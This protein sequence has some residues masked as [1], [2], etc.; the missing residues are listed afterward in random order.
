MTRLA[1]A[2]LP[3]RLQIAVLLVVTQLL[4]HFVTIGV[5]ELST[6]NLRS[7]QADYVSTMADPLITAL[8][9]VSPASEDEAAALLVDLAETDPRFTVLSAPKPGDLALSENFDPDLARVVAGRVPPAW[10]DRVTITSTGPSPWSWRRA[11]EAALAVLV[12]LP[13]GRA[14]R[15][16]SDPHFLGP[17]LPTVVIVPA[18]LLLALPLM[19]LSVWAGSALVAPITSLAR[20]AERF[21]SDIASPPITES[22]PEEV[23]RASRAFN[24]MRVRIRKLIDS[25]S[26]TL[27][28]IGHDMR[29]PLTRLRLRLEALDMGSTTSAAEEDIRSLERMIDDAL[30]FLQ[31]E[32]QPLVLGAI[33][34]AVLAQ[35]IVDDFADRGHRVRYEGPFHLPLVCDHDHIRRVLENLVGNATKYAEDT[36][37]RV[38]GEDDGSLTIHVADYGPG[39]APEHHEHVLEPFS[40]IETVRRGGESAGKSFGLGLAIA[41]DLVTRH[42]GFLKLGQN[43]PEGLLVTIRLPAPAGGPPHL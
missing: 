7:R 24:A 38:T 20:G 19:L 1:I 9:L 22:G 36:L 6:P 33:D 13:D 27:A 23:R 8:R 4:A 15:Y 37:V 21:S 5:L 28:A 26:Q 35:T 43:V 17:S 40:R 42:G 2:R 30:V 32:Q 3:I 31:S 10:R 11:E 14:V 41:R 39:I 12:R 25:R 34:V 16:A 29:T 18:L